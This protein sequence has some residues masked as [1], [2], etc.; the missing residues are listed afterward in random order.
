MVGLSPSAVT[1]LASHPFTI[2]EDTEAGSCQLHA[3]E[4]TTLETQFGGY[5]SFPDSGFSVLCNS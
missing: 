4:Q 3:Q 1:Q 2:P 5:F